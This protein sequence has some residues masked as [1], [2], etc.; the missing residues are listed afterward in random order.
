L[1]HVVKKDELSGLSYAQNSEDLMCMRAAQE[2]G[3]IDDPSNFLVVDIGASD[4]VTLSNSRIFLE[5]GCSAI[6]VDSDQRRFSSLERNSVD[7][8][9]VK[10]LCR[11]INFDYTV[12]SLMK[13]F[14]SKFEIS[15]LT[16]DV[17]GPDL[18]ILHQALEFHP[19]IVVIEYNPSIPLHVNF[20]QS[21]FD[22]NLGNSAK[23]IFDFM[24]GE[25]YSLF[26]ATQTNLLFHQ[27]SLKPN[28]K[29]A[30]LDQYLDDSNTVKAIWVGYD[31]SV[32]F[33]GRQRLDFPWH[34]LDQLI[35]I[36][37]IPAYLRH[38]YGGSNFMQIRKFL[39]PKMKIILNFRD[40]IL[41]KLK[42]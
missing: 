37:G 25:G 13:E 6:L 7:F 10:L 18:L 26:N 11:K 9:N 14:A 3:L 29:T 27:A 23:S 28:S 12:Q 30:Q 33:E 38:F 8:S 15:L 41:G 21:N 36:S 40:R 32:N 42:F 16:I 31:G 35:R 22:S 34:G 17:D 4:G 39:W 5:I 24:I 1:I 19:K 20:Q 2:F